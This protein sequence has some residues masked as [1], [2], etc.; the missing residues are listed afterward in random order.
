MVSKPPINDPV[1]MAEFGSRGCL[2]ESDFSVYVGEEAC[3][4]EFLY[5]K[6]K[7]RYPYLQKLYFLSLHFIAIALLFT[8]FCPFGS[9]I[10]KPP[11][12][13]AFRK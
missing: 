6:C 4:H 1:I 13:A 10:D 12:H 5:Q 9:K 2:V 3:S 11:I 7:K 8:T